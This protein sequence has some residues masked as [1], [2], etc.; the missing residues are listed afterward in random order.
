MAVMPRF[1]FLL[2]ALCALS[3]RAAPAAPP[4]TAS[5]HSATRADSIN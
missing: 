3:L 1:V 5:N 4:Q 2:A